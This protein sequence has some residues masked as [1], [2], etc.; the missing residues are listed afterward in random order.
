MLHPIFSTLIQRPD[1]VMGH[2]S[3]YG[4]LFSQEAKTA[5]GELGK[6]A[7]AWLLVV[8]CGSVFVSMTGV[9]LMLGLMQNQFHWVLVAVPG[10][11]L[12]ITIVALLQAKKPLDANHFNELKAQLSS[13]ASALRLVA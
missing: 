8:L 9:A 1:L 12:L 3:A 11:A 10:A 13:D 6:R 2:L 4:A 5:A 7:L